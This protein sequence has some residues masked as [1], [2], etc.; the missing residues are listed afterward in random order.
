M[1]IR[2][3]TSDDGPAVRSIALRSMEASYSL[4]P[5]VIESAIR[6]WYGPDS[7]RDKLEDDEVLLLLVE[8]DDEAIA[9]S[10][11]AL[12]DERGD[13]HWLHVAA[14]YR[15]EGIGHRLYEET[16]ERLEDAG[17]ETVRG[18]VLTM[19]SEGNRFWQNRGLTKVGEGTVEIDGTAFVEN[20]YVDETD[21]E[22]QPI[23]VDDRELY[24]DRGESERGS[25]GPFYTVYTDEAAEN[26]YSYF[27]GSCE[28][29]IT[30][31][32]TMG[33]LSCEECGNQLKPTRWD[34]A[35]M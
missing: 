8:E 26:R 29:L 33:R 11:S 10:E 12:V 32:D 15:G 22:L 30:S 25:Q 6:Q 3:A 34:A 16:R 24:I 23:V 21:I 18:L 14:M 9:F 28:T 17:A 4:S 1:E 5:S 2:E 13:I 7:F 27:C 31:M 20:I 35:Y 19:N